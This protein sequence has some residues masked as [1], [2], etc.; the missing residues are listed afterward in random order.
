MNG[1]TLCPH[2]DTRFKIVETQLEAHQGMVRCGHCLQAFDARPGFIPDQPSPQLELPILNEPAPP[3][4]LADEPPAVLAALDEAAASSITTAPDADAFAHEAI[5]MDDVVSNKSELDAARYGMLDYVEMAAAAQNG[6]PP[7]VPLPP[8][9]ESSQ[10]M[11]LA[12]QVAIVQDEDDSEYRPERRTWP[13]AMAVLLLLL[14]SIAQAAYFFRVDL[15]ARLPGLKPALVSYCQL[16]KCTVPLPQN[17]DL[18]SIESS[19]LEADPAHENQIVL[20]ALLRNRAPYSQA[21]PN[22]ELTLNDT[23][24]NAL[25]RRV[26]RPADYL[27]PLESETIGLLSQHEISVRLH[28]ETTDLRPTGYRLALLYPQP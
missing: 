15:A 8:E 7:G 16:L 28:L 25:A 5:N 13:W 11:T 3:H 26:F 10:P 17:T 22:L 23:R 21:F 12:E 2:C 9:T 20:N 19:N 27:P 6:M 4:K 24:D 18:M 14:V 1:T